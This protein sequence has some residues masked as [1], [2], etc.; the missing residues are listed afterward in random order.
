MQAAGHASLRQLA[1]ARLVHR[2]RKA[3]QGAL[4]HPLLP[5]LDVQSSESPPRLARLPQYSLRIGLHTSKH[6][7]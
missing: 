6:I 4:H 2:A 3:K 7:Q 1:G 5:C